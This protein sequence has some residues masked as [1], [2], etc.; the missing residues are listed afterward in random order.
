MC[1]IIYFL[2]ILRPLETAKEPSKWISNLAPKILFFHAGTAHFLDTVA[3]WVANA[4]SYH[5]SCTRASRCVLKVSE[6]RAN[7]VVAPP[8]AQT[9]KISALENRV[10]FHIFCYHS[11]SAA[12]PKKSAARGAKLLWRTPLSRFT[13][14]RFQTLSTVVATLEKLSSAPLLAVMMHF[15]GVYF[16]YLSTK[17]ILR[18]P[19]EAIWDHFLTKIFKMRFFHSFSFCVLKT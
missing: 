8:T 11:H 18:S 3:F 12:N 19:Q 16:W 5:E 14:N 2:S 15:F 9:K 1:F 6:A 10:N 4:A 17:R 13:P 7:I